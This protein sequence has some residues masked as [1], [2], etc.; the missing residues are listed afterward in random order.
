VKYRFV[1]A[2]RHEFT[3]ARMCTALAVSRSGFYAWQQRPESERTR[4][5]RALIARMRI[6]HQQTREAYGA[7]KMWHL[8]RREGL[9]CGRHRVA[10]L[11]RL[12]GLVALRRRRYVRTIQA[13]HQDLVAIPNR[14]AQQFTVTQK[15]RVW[16]GDLTFIPTRS[17]WLYVAVLL[18]LYSRRVVGWAMSE[19][20]SP[21]V[22]IDAWLMAWQQRRPPAGLLH[23]SDQGKQYRAS[24]YQT[25]LTRRGAI[26]SLSRKGNCYDNAVVESFFSTLKNE[27]VRHRQFQDQA[28]ARRAI[29]DYLEGFYN[30]QRLHQTLGYRSPEEFEQQDS[31]S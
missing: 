11:R 13:R 29:F 6:L 18:D 19:R 30:R 8:L 22:V 23:H 26:L 5:N 1:Q 14:L 17:G 28:E 3:V 24:V 27:L 16:A 9:A 31:D 10:R 4:A 21:A 15:N 7:R 25:M 12:A 20:Q 2:H